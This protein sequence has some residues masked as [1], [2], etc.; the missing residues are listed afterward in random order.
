MPFDY[1]HPAFRRARDQ[2]FERSGGVCQFCGLEEAEHAHH[3]SGYM[4]RHYKPPE[5]TK[6]EDLTALCSA[7]H[8]IA[9]AIKARHKKMVFDEEHLNQ[10]K[11][12]LAEEIRELE[13]ERELLYRRI[14]E[15]HEE[16]AIAYQ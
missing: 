14:K 7:C 12:E 8:R 9:T 13:E 4:E 11:E 5:E 16:K 2:A 1:Q 10:K 15:F 3:W 6:P